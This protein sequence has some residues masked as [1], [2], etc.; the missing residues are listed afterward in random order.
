[1]EN[2]AVDVGARIAPCPSREG[3]DSEQPPS[4]IHTVESIIRPVA[5]ARQKAKNQG[6]RLIQL[7]SAPHSRVNSRRANIRMSR[8]YHQ[9][10][11]SARKKS[12]LIAYRGGRRDV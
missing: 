1:M 10:N 6:M 12:K 4:E 2:P 7:C 11:R 3:L 5:C 9:T 8:Q